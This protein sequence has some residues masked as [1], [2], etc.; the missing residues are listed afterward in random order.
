VVLNV[1]TP[2][3]FLVN[4]HF[5]RSFDSVPQV[6]DYQC[7]LWIFESIFYLF[8]DNGSRQPA[9]TI[10]TTAWGVNGL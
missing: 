2:I 8:I 3:L 7:A 6:H 4:W 1:T 10:A 9:Q 5:Y